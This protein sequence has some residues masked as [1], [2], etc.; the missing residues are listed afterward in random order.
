MMP[1]IH[2]RAVCEICGEEILGEKC[3]VFETECFCDDCVDREMNKIDPRL[4]WW[5]R[6]YLGDHYKDTPDWWEE[7]EGMP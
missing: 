6:D 7:E 1:A 5:V 2:R 4:E 3:Y